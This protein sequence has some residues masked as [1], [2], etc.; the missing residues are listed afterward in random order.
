M[1]FPLESIVLV[2]ALGLDVV[3]GELPNRWHPVAWMGRWLAFVCRAAPKSGAIVPL[4]A[5]VAI[6]GSGAVACAIIGWQI[7]GLASDGW[8]TGAVLLQAVVLKQTFSARSLARAA[9]N[10]EAALRSGDLVAARQLL[11]YHL[12]SRDVSNLDAP[13]VAA[14]TIESVAE[15]ASDSIVAPLFYFAIAG[16]PGALAYR[17]INTCDAMIGYRCDEYE[18]LG[19]PAARLDDLANLLPARL[20]AA[21]ILLSGPALRQRP[22]TGLTIWFR[23]RGATAS[24]NAGQPMS[25]AAGVLGIELEKIGCYRLGSGQRLPDM[26]DI[27][28]ATRLIWTASAIASLSVLLWFFVKDA[29]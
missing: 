1:A 12:V 16:L 28:R 20:T 29:V 6:V 23:D 17:F 22:L 7:E 27:S 21:M 5:G 25:A 11:G 13:Q 15:N 2:T 9:G 18:W 26:S 4:A 19:K 8:Y 24:P 14:A 3:F 10:V